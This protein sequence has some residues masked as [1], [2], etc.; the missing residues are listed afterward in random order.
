MLR[1]I[2]S[3]MVCAAFVLVGC[4]DSGDEESESSGT[5]TT[6]V[7]TTEQV[8]SPGATDCGSET[9]ALCLD[10]NRVPAVAGPVEIVVE[11]KRWEG[12]QEVAVYTCAEAQGDSTSKVAMGT[13]VGDPKEAME[14][15]RFVKLNVSE[16]S[17]STPLRIEI[18]QAMID[19]GG[20]VI[21]AG[22]IWIPNAAAHT[23]TIGD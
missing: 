9:E 15:G 13:C 7:S 11:G 5:E 17:F 20:I 4:S 3:W 19:A 23:L 10:P 2:A 1:T 16:G 8:T 14:S 12:F 21:A 6:A 22:D 18:D